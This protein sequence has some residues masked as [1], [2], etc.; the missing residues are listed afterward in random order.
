MH[1]NLPG[2]RHY[3]PTS[4]VSP[5]LQFALAAGV[6]L[7]AIWSYHHAPTVR[8]TDQWVWNYLAAVAGL[9]GILLVPFAVAALI[10]VL[11]NRRVQ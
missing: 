9:M 11:R 5:V 4:L 2:Q 1:V 8:V 6:L 10:R 7:L 3:R